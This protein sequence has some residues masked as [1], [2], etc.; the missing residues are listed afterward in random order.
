MSGF[1]LKHI[2]TGF[3][4][5]RLAEGR[6]NSGDLISDPELWRQ[7][8]FEHRDEVLA[9]FGPN[10]D[11]VRRFEPELLLDDDDEEGEEEEEGDD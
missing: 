10:C 8:Y 11:A 9:R 5:I 6:P 4:V 3:A 1:E 7:V 2:G